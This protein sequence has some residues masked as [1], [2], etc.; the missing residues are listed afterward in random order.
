MVYP[1]DKENTFLA[2]QGDMLSLD[3]ADILF[4][5]KWRVNELQRPGDYPNYIK[6]FNVPCSKLV[7]HRYEGHYTSQVRH[8]ILP[9]RS[10]AHID[11]VYLLAKSTIVYNICLWATKTT[12]PAELF[13]FDSETDY[14]EFI[15]EES[16]GANSVAHY[17]LDIGSW[18]SPVCTQVEFIASKSSYYFIT[19]SCSAEVAYQYNI[20]SYVNYLNWT[21]YADYP[22]C[23]IQESVDSCSLTLDGRIF[24]P[25]EDH[26]LLAHVAKLPPYLVVPPT[27]HM[28][29]DTKRRYTVVIVPA[30]LL[31]IVV[32]WLLVYLTILWKCKYCRPQTHGYQRI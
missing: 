5:E 26:C 15:D 14:Q 25:H 22:S 27:T 1:K 3:K 11:F 20:T 28:K 17:M 32:L 16:N 29:V 4:Y 24:P 21:D 6:L 19:A 9:T 2:F 31:V 10:L 7:T 30:C 12:P 13:A 18:A 8:L 23:A